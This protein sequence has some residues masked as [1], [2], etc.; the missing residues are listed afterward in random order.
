MIDRPLSSAARWLIVLTAFATLWALA[1]VYFARS[2]GRTSVVVAD[3]IS[4]FVWP[5]ILAVALNRWLGKR[6]GGK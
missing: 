1:T 5:A 2:D 3:L 4:G 6:T